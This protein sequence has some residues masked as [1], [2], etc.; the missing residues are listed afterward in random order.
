MV[1]KVWSQKGD[2]PLTQ[3]GHR[4]NWEKE[5]GDKIQLTVIATN[6]YTLVH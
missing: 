6:M 1:L 4:V 5:L 2:T 3:V